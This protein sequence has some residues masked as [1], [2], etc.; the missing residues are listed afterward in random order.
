MT[1]TFSTQFPHP[2]SIECLC[3]ELFRHLDKH[4]WS[5]MKLALPCRVT[6]WDLTS[7]FILLLTPIELLIDFFFPPS[8]PAH[9]PETPRSTL[10]QLTQCDV[11]PTSC[12]SAGKP[13]Q[14]RTHHSKNLTI[15]SD[16]T[17]KMY[18]WLSKQKVYSK[19]KKNFWERDGFI[20]LLYNII[21]M[22]VG[23]IL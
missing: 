13:T 19:F 3:W 12:N 5:L 20:S 7:S 6:H 18:I 21:I 4:H 15:L 9:A 17:F 22:C 2:F 16:T 23:V 10:L 8:S 11:F 1:R 14:I